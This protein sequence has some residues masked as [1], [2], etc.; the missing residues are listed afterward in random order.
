MV[1]FASTVGKC[2]LARPCI[3][4]YHF[5]AAEYKS[6]SPAMLLSPWAL[7]PLGAAG[8]A[9]HFALYAR[10]GSFNPQPPRRAILN[11]PPPSNAGASVAYAV[12]VARTGNPRDR[13]FGDFAVRP[14]AGDHG[15]TQL[16]GAMR[17]LELSRDIR[18][19]WQYNDLCYNVFGLPIER[20]S[21]QSYESFI[22]SRLTNRL[23]MKLS[24]TLEDLEASPEAAR[25]YMMR[26]NL[27]LPAVRLPIRTMAGGAINTSIA[28]LADAAANS[29]V[30]AC[31]LRN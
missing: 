1:G 18:G 13:D 10:P 28:D 22:R 7:L 8:D 30:S 23:G 4:G 9:P 21:G 19:A 14:D 2:L 5:D 17:Y 26:E 6:P 15:P 27:R 3:I 25:P 20:I 16:L 24:F 12:S 11:P 31:C 29:R